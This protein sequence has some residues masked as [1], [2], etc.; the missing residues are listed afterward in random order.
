MSTFRIELK[1]FKHYPRL[2]Q[3]TTAYSADLYVD[4]FKVG[5]VDNDGHGGMD[6]ARLS[7]MEPGNS[8]ALTYFWRNAK[9]DAQDVRMLRDALNRYVANLPP[10]E[11]PHGPIRHTGLEDLTMTLAENLINAAAD[12]KWIDKCRKKNLCPWIVTVGD[13]TA[14]M[15][16]KPGAT[17]DDARR[18]A[19]KEFK[20]AESPP[21][22][23]LPRPATLG[24]AYLLGDIDLAFFRV[25]SDVQEEQGTRLAHKPP[26]QI[27]G[28]L[29]PIELAQW[30]A[31]AVP[32]RKPKRAALAGDGAWRV[33]SKWYAKDDG[34]RLTDCC[35]TY[36]TYCEETLC[37]KACYHEVDVGQGDGSEHITPR[38]VEH[39]IGAAP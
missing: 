17:V 19:G 2:S 15:G 35:G 12:A 23:M 18:A 33:G 32:A 30:A 20:D 26:L 9:I 31:G 16:L 29:T 24:D 21:S 14:T 39:S 7:A 34:Q 4:G 13:Q 37:C 11:T 36:S 25:L 6:N 1:R 8:P 3:E 28:G 22:P 10:E 27:P 38:A 5:I